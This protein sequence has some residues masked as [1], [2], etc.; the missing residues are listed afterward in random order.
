M[1][2]RIEL[3]QPIRAHGE[4]R[5]ALDLREPTG[6]DIAACGYPFRF[7]AAADGADTQILP[8]A[9]AISALIARLGEV[10]KGS[11]DQLSLADWQACMT[12]VLGFFGQAAPAIPSSGASSLPGSGNGTRGLR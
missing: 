8:E 4:E 6:G 11:V 1:S 10:P 7:V 3:S 2:I 12:A 5:M 9:A